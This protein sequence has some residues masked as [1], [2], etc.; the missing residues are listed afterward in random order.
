[1]KKLLK[2]IRPH[3][4]LKN[5]FVFIP[6]FFGGGLLNTD[7]IVHGIIT[8]FSF[9]FIAS[10]IYCFNDIIDVDDDRR[11]PIKCQRP[12]ASGAIG[13]TS[14]YVL[15]AVMV[16]LSFSLLLLLPS[17]G[18]KVAAVVLFYFVM[19]L[20][21]CAKLKQYAILDVCI[22]AFGFVLRILAG[23]TATGI[24]LSNWL[25]LM[26]FLL[27]LFLSF[28]KRRDD[29]VRM[30]ETGEAPRQNTI[31]YNLTFINQAI[32]ITASVTLVC[33]VMYTV[34]PDVTS[35]FNTQY[36]YLTSIFVLVGLLR[37]I[38][39]TVVDK[40]SGDPTKILMR[41][42]FTQLIVVGWISAFLVIIYLL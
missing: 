18:G 11:H 27:T 39:L 8:F 25:V 3:Q 16:L 22:I 10:S 1:M 23:G 24:M 12:I 21:Y 35:R 15:M 40:R 14:A 13:I 29:V 17:Q 6:M 33:Y 28:A 7:N 30:N 9:S 4:W 5:G 37:Y 38:Q 26:T 31:R 32:T 36:L 34:S 2:L 41:D 20:T 42:R 19:N